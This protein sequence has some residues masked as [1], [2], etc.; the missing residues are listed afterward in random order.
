[1]AAC[2]ALI[3]SSASQA[4]DQLTLRDGR[5]L[6]GILAG[7]QGGYVAIALEPGVEQRFRPESIASIAFDPDNAEPDRLAS[8]LGTIGAEDELR[9]IEH[10]KA[11]LTQG[12]FE[13][14]LER[15]KLWQA[16]FKHEHHGLEARL[17]QMQA[18]RLL[19]RHAEAATYARAWIE[20]LVPSTLSALPWL[21]LA[22]EH[23]M[24]DRHAE[25]LWLCLHPIAFRGM[26]DPPYLPECYALAERSAN[27]IELT[28]Y[29]EAL[30]A[31]ARGD[32]PVDTASIPSTR[33]PALHRLIGA[34]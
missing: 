7:R 32:P 24:A 12:D 15:S 14:A 19:D 31:E 4:A 16:A 10:L 33:H 5:I 22:E 25:A 17:I 23:A 11:I 2:A 27:A 1:M 29:A 28:A 21:I 30:A 20:R 8:Y 13:T 26:T 6:S 18:A 34:P 3:V 9:L